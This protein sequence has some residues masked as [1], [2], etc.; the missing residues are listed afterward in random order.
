[1]FFQSTD[2][3]RKCYGELVKM[4]KVI[5]AVVTPL[6]TKQNPYRITNKICLTP[7]P[8]KGILDK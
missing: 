7:S 4:N 3:G 5:Q 1:M 8:D 2:N 6:L